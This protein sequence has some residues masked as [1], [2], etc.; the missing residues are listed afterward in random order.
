MSP[1]RFMPAV[2]RIL[3]V[4]DSLQ[5]ELLIQ[6]QLKKDGFNIEVKRV[7]TI[8]ELKKSL[9]N[10]KWT[11]LLSDFHLPGFEAF[12]V[13]KVVSEY[14]HETLP[15][16]VVSGAVGEEKAVD[17]IRAGASDF[18]MKDRLL[19]L[20]IVVERVLKD[21]ASK[22]HSRAELERLAKESNLVIETIPQ[23]IWRCN[24]DGAA[25]YFS[26]RFYSLVGYSAD[27]FLGWGWSEVL[28]PD[29]KQRVIDEWKDCREKKVPFSIEFRIQMKDGSYRWFLS[30][31]NPFFNTTGDL[32]KYY[33]TWTDIHDKKISA[34]V[35]KKS[36]EEF[37]ELANSMPQ[38]VW[39]A[40]SDGTVDYY[41]DRIRELLGAQKNSDGSWDWSG[42][43][44]EEDRQKTIEM[45]ENAVKSRRP[46][47]IEHR[48]KLS[49][50]SFRW[51]LS[52]GTPVVKDDGSVR[53]YGTATDIDQ[54]KKNEK[55]LKE[56]LRARD[57][58]LSVASHELKTP[59]TS[60]SLQFQIQKKGMDKK[61]PKILSEERIT[62]L[63]S[64]GERLIKRLNVLVEDMLDVS[65]IRTGNL[66]I[67]KAP[68]DISEVLSDVLE[69]MDPMFIDGKYSLPQFNKTEIRGSFDAYRIEQVFT[70]LI[71]NAI[72]YGNSNPIEIEM[73]QKENYVH[74][75]IKDHGRGI[76]PE[77]RDKIFDRFE[78]A[79]DSKEISGLGLGL[80]I[81]KKIVEAHDG[82]IWV[83]SKLN[84]G[85]TFHVT[86]PLS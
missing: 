60:L 12:E 3:M 66:S 22:L 67:N 59:L 52:R 10:E 34:E 8:E 32:T 44:H 65:R 58:F 47:S 56:A 29:D 31:G 57:E 63:T 24:P 82:K 73:Y 55:E 25:D 72:R 33:G 36:E 11:L 27:E 50:G 77:M 75:A 1:A 20:P 43:L 70:N 30:L 39:T 83:E 28:H 40:K 19:R 79:V 41:N 53:W 49:D 78:R 81:T 51:Y 64:L 4:E 26:K 21:L 61:D 2:V 68:I 16:I 15:V 62:Q 23:G 76:P 46:Y 13:L 6:R 71:S 84:E 9:V 80:Y 38:I 74:F 85:S 48:V 5:D 54:Q 42:M 86:L 35:I 17:I 14:S 69:R 45:W 37:R 7:E 18:V